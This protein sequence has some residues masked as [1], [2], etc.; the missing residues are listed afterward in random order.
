MRDWTGSRAADALAKAA[1]AQHANV[2]R[3]KDVAAAARL[4]KPALVRFAVVASIGLARGADFL[5]K[6]VERQR[7]A[8]VGARPGGHHLVGLHPRGCIGRFG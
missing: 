6:R 2:G 1:A 8:I 4:A 7:D 3:V 5:R